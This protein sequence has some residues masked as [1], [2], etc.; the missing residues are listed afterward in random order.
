ML[1]KGSH[2]HYFSFFIKKR[3]IIKFPTNILQSI[4]KPKINMFLSNSLSY[5]LPPE[6]SD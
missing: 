1:K 6:N 3:Y 5:R 2:S 4:S